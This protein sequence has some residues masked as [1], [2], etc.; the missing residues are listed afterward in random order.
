MLK[1]TCHCGSKV[2]FPGGSVGIYNASCSGCDSSY[3]MTRQGETVAV[4]TP[5]V[6]MEVPGVPDDQDHGHP[7]A[8]KEPHKK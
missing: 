3:R 6:A 2:E 4:E 7:I 5:P 1:I 8:G